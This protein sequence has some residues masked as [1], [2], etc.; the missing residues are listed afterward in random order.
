[1]SNEKGANTH[2]APIL[3]RSEIILKAN[4]NSQPTIEFPSNTIT[5]LP[6]IR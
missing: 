3:S 6:S 1:M 2:V 4:V 5:Q